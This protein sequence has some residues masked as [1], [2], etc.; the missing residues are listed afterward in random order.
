MRARKRSLVWT[1]CARF[2]FTLWAIKY[3]L[4]A[5]LSKSEYELH[6][7]FVTSTATTLT[8]TTTMAPTQYQCTTFTYNLLLN[9]DLQI[10]IRMNLTNSDYWYTWNWNKNEQFDREAQREINEKTVQK[11]FAKA[12]CITIEIDLMV[13]HG[14]HS[15]DKFFSRSPSTVSTARSRIERRWINENSYIAMCAHWWANKRLALKSNCNNN[16]RCCYYW[17]SNLFS[18]VVN[19][20]ITISSTSANEPLLESMTNY[21]K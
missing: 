20:Y 17:T 1:R 3:L 9:Y 8:T 18:F 11:H 7:H 4:I 6:C 12:A 21:L 13:P 19:I 16:R 10:W 2:G 5:L 14:R 15:E